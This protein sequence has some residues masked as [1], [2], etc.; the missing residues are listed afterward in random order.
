MSKTKRGRV[1]PMRVEVEDCAGCPW[2]GNV[3]YEREPLCWRVTPSQ[4]LAEHVCDVPDW[5]PLRERPVLV[6]LADATS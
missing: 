3:G 2:L 4:S 6:V 1:E 5:C